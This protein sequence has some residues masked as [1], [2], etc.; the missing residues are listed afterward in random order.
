MSMLTADQA[1]H[2]DH[3]VEV[4]KD[5]RI[6]HLRVANNTLTR[7]KGDDV[8][9]SLWNLFCEQWA[10]VGLEGTSSDASKSVED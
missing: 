3:H 5:A 6:G 7:F 4:Q 10:D 2:V 1:S 9:P 8:W